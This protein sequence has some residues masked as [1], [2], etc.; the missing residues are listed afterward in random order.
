MSTRSCLS[1]SQALVDVK[2]CSIESNVRNYLAREFLRKNFKREN[3]SYEI[4][5]NFPRITVYT[6]PYVTLFTTN[7]GERSE[8]CTSE[9]N[10]NSVCMY[11]ID[12]PVALRMR[13][14]MLST[15]CSCAR[16]TN[17]LHSPSILLMLIPVQE[18][19][20]EL[21]KHYQWEVLA[22]QDLTYKTLPIVRP[23]HDIQAIFTRIPQ[24]LPA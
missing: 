15:C 21:L 22:D 10:A 20:V 2:F 16:P 13:R 11:V 19:T 24:T 23:K 6:E 8:P 18:C 17:A 1:V 5:A 4:N 14:N 12:R 9:V 7:W 3:L